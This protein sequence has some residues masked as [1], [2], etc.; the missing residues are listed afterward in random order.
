M[1]NSDTTVQ[2]SNRDCPP[3]A[4]E[5]ASQESFR[6][7]AAESGSERRE[8]P[9]PS[10]MTKSPLPRHLFYMT[11]ELG[12]LKYPVHIYLRAICAWIRV[13]PLAALI[14]NYV[15]GFDSGK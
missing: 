9:A 11:E 3:L 14:P 7:V 10:H 8:Y 12:Q 13:D 2:R 6:R 1:N 4:V 15:T 5:G